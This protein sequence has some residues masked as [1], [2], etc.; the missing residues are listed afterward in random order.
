VPV[1]GPEP[2][3]VPDPGVVVAPAA[4]PE[5][6]VVLPQK[7]LALVGIERQQMPEPTMVKGMLEEVDFADSRSA[8]RFLDWQRIR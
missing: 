1:L 4:A 6:A 7:R 8:P 5:T 3:A 2:A